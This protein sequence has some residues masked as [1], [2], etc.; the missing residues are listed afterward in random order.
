MTP[1]Q[2]RSVLALFLL[3]ICTWQD[4]KDKSIYLPIPL[5]WASAALILTWACRDMSAFFVLTGILT[6]AGM[7]V[8]SHVSHG[9]IGS[10]DGWVLCACGACLGFRQ[11]LILLMTALFFSMAY[12]AFMLL[13]GRKKR[14]DTV[15]FIPFLMAAFMCMTAAGG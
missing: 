12:C 13:I 4:L 8:L 7:V 3:S 2:I 5:G 14:H 1:E 11:T 10:G 9:E 6:G 15:P